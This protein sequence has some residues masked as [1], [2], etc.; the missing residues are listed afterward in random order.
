MSE[1][2]ACP[3]C[4]GEAE[5]AVYGNTKQG[6]SYQCLECSCTLETSE[7]FN[8]GYSWNN[9][10][11]ENKLKADAVRDEIEYIKSNRPH[12]HLSVEYEMMMD[13]LNKLERGEK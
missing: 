6:T 9:R 1:L 3:F 8:H 4:I 2:K 12:W 11:Y 7:T 13:R 5:I 10:P